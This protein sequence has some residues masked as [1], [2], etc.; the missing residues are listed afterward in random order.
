MAVKTRGTSRTA[1]RSRRTVRGVSRSSSR[2]GLPTPRPTRIW[3]LVGIV[4]VAAFS[5]PWTVPWLIDGF[6]ASLTLCGLGLALII[7]VLAIDIWVAIKRVFALTKRFWR[8]TV[9]LHMLIITGFAVLALIRPDWTVGDV[10]LSESTLGGE[11]GY[12]FVSS[13]IGL[14]ALSVVTLGGA[15]LVWPSGARRGVAGLVTGTRFIGDELRGF[16][17][18]QVDDDLDEST[19]SPYISQLD[20]DFA[21]T[22]VSEKELEVVEE[23]PVSVEQIAETDGGEE[24]IVAPV[25][26]SRTSKKGELVGRPAGSGWELPPLELLSDNTENTRQIDNEARAQLIIDTLKSFGVDASVVSINQGPTVTQFGIEPGWEMKTRT[27]IERDSDGRPVKDSEGNPKHRTEVTSRT[28]IRV[29]KITSLANDIALALAS[30][31]IRI[32]APVPGKPVIGIELPNTITSLVTLRSILESASFRRVSS[33][34]RLALSLGK[35]V[36][37]EPVAADLAKMPH[38][39]IAGATGSGKSVAVNSI[40]SCLLMQNTPEDVRLILVDPKR[41][42]LTPFADIPHLAFSHVI[43][44][45]EEVVGT[46]QAVIYEMESRYRKFTKVAVRNI[47]GYNKSPQVENKLPHWVVVID[48]LADLM[49]VASYEVERQICRLAQLARATGIHLIIATQRPSV[50]VVTGLI[51][52]NFPTRIAFAVSS[53]VDSRTILDGAG[54]EKLLGKGDMLFQSTDAAKPKRLQGSFVSDK[55]TDRI[56]D[57][58]KSDRFRHLS[59][60]HMDHLIV[61]AAS[62]GDDDPGSE[63][64]PSDD[65]LLETAREL[66]LQHSRISTSLLQRRLRVGYPRAA[67]LIDILEEQGVVSEA[68]GSGQ[69]RRVLASEEEEEDTAGLID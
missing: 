26:A 21:T 55:E 41:V 43:T 62:E 20:E 59:P 19:D 48:E 18:P 47:E 2:S 3:L 28:R 42:E 11:F 29:N 38:L 66:A 51:K 68:D 8:I 63:N 64:K 31:S 69:S 49:I 45:M 1:Y 40:I 14:L 57:W 22:I 15:S 13:A 30:P 4:A 50:D 32:E 6:E 35:G 67:R 33:R 36:S 65:P 37:G 23:D 39:L 44:D 25:S 56:V 9:G 61:E 27:V 58:W 54:A 46:L 17:A 12:L 60:D 53:Q 7:A 52:A 24:K 34:S 5:S 10:S 16:F